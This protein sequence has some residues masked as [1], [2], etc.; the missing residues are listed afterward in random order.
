MKYKYKFKTKTREKIAIYG[1][2]NIN[3]KIT[4]LKSYVNILIVINVNW[5]QEFWYN[6]LSIIL[7]ARKNVKVCW[8]KVGQLLEIIVD[9][10]VFGLAIIIKN[11][12]F[13]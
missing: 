13:I 7:L 5:V 1:Y 3:W 12:C 11:Q 8:R 9:K 10:E 6:L 2:K 4:N